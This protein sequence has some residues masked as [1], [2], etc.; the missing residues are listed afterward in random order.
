[1][2]DLVKI[3]LEKGDHWSLGTLLF[4]V[5]LLGYH[6]IIAQIEL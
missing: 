3:V 1:M 5:I 6:P 2:N 4:C